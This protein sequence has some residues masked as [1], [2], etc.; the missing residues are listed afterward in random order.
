MKTKQLI[1]LSKIVDKLEIKNE[2][3]N[4]KGESNEEI[5]EKLLALIITNLHKAEQEIYEFIA[6]YKGITVEEAENEDIIK[7]L[8]DIFDIKGMKDFLSSTR[9]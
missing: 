3:T 7:L 8:T 1:K 6:V 4:I 5:A 9:D 2:L